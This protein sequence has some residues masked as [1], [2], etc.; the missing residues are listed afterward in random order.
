MLNL[1]MTDREVWDVGHADYYLGEPYKIP[2]FFE[3][4]KRRM[5]REPD[6]STISFRTW[7]GEYFQFYI[8]EYHHNPALVCTSTLLDC[9]FF[10]QKRLSIE[11]MRKW[12][13]EQSTKKHPIKGSYTG[14][15]TFGKLLL[16]QYAT[17]E[18]H[19]AEQEIYFTEEVL[20]R[21]FNEL[22][23]RTKDDR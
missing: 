14:Y 18:K 1:M 4:S 21:I 6:Y 11:K 7:K 2:Y 20:E 23:R 12:A 10:M 13:E 17:L 9:A 8:D 22:K 3:T 15:F 16:E 5:M 19:M